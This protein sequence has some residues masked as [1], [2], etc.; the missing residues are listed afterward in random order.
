MTNYGLTSED[1]VKKL[2]ENIQDVLT[3][4]KRQRAKTSL[5]R[6]FLAAFKRND[7]VVLTSWAGVVSTIVVI[8][9]MV[10]FAAVSDTQR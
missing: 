7:P 3:D 9:T 5:C 6:F 10:I 8:V 1:S 2:E 4:N